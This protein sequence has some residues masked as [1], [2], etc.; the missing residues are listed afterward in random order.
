MAQAQFLPCP[1]CG[2]HV[3]S[4]E[5]ECPFCRYV[6]SGGGA[7]VQTTMGL[8]AKLSALLLGVCLV[9][10]AGGSK[11]DADAGKADAG[12]VEQPAKT[13]S[14]TPETPPADSADGGSSVVEDPRP[15][16]KYGGPPAPDGDDSINDEPRPEVKYGGPP[17]DEVPTPTPEPSVVEPS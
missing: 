2:R 7:V 9:G 12:K 1:G 17:M 6:H 14:D 10:C 4:S 8:P 3:R 5:L 13:T 16:E 11:G 15:A